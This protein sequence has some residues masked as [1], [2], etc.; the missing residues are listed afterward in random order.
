MT[1]QINGTTGI[2]LPH[3]LAKSSGGSGVT[4]STQLGQIVT[5]QTGALASG[6]T[7]FP[8][9]LAAPVNT[10]GDQYMSLSINPTNVNS[11]LEIDILWNGTSN[12]ANAIGVGLFRDATVNAL[13]ASQMY[14]S[15]ATGMMS[16]SLKHFVV[17]G[18]LSPT[19][20]YIRAGGANVGT[21]SFNGGSPT[22]LFYGGV[23]AS[24][25]TIK[26]YLP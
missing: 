2:V 11:I 14:M 3:P 8:R 10:A 9:S 21:T 18:S 22:V 23:F 17:A 26:E 20:F 4:I 15:A 6:N 5:F 16:I 19:T 24:R 12:V 1:V 25:I 13:S 7:I